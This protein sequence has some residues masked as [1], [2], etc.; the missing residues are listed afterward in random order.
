M[1]TRTIESLR[2]RTD[3]YCVLTQTATSLWGHLEAEDLADHMIGINATDSR[4]RTPLMW[5]A[6]YRWP[7][8]VGWLVQL[9]TDANQLR[10]TCGGSLPM[11]YLAIA[12]PEAWKAS[13]LHAVTALCKQMPMLTMSSG[14]TSL[15]RI[16]EGP[17]MYMNFVL[18]LLFKLSD[19]NP[20]IGQAL[21]PDTR[22][23]KC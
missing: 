9:G 13:T 16:C 23:S 17:F 1:S 10:S 11:L 20:N 14:H 3:I 18:N 8:A 7:D 2:Q 15:L 4:G 5:A 21:R 19:W 22:T 6:G 12:G